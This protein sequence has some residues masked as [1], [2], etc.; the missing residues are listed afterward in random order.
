MRKL[1]GVAV[2]F[3]ILGSVTSLVS[4]S[5]TYPYMNG[6]F[7][8]EPEYHTYPEV[9][10]ELSLIEKDHPNIANVFSLGL[11][12]EKRDIFCIKISDNV[13]TDEKEPE[14]FIC[15]LHH[16]REA[17]AVEVA[18]YI[19]NY[20]TDVYGQP[21]HEQVTALVDNREIYIVP[22]V[23][24]DGKV[25]DD[26]GGSDGE[27]RYWRKNRQPCSN[28]IGTDLNRNYSYQWGGLGSS[29]CCAHSNS[30][31]GYEP[32]DAPETRAVKNFIVNHPDITV[33]LDYHSFGG[34]VL[35][36]WGY[37]SAPLSDLDD[38][39]VHEIIGRQYATITSYKFMKM[40]ELYYTSGNAIDWCYS[41]TKDNE[42]PIFS[43][44]IELEGR[45]FYPSPAELLPLCKKNCE[46]ALYVIS[47][48]DDPYKVLRRWKVS[49]SGLVDGNGYNWFDRGYDDSDW[50]MIYMPDE[51]S[52]NLFY[53]HVFTCYDDT[54]Q[55]LLDVPGGSTVYV[56][57]EYI[58]HQDEPGKDFFDITSSIMVGR[59]LVAV[60]VEPSESV[61]IKIIQRNDMYDDKIW[62]A[63]GESGFTDWYD[64]SYDDSDWEMITLPDT[65]FYGFYRRTFMVPRYTQVF[66]DFG[67]DINVD[68]DIVEIYV[69]GKQLNQKEYKKRT[70]THLHEKINITSYT[71]EGVNLVAVH[72]KN[73]NPF[74]A[75]LIR[76]KVLPDLRITN[77]DISFSDPKPTRGERITIL[78]TVHNDITVPDAVLRFYDGPPEE[79]QLIDECSVALPATSSSFKTMWIYPGSTHEIHVVIDE[80]NTI[81]EPEESNNSAH[82]TVPVPDFYTWPMFG[83]DHNH[84]GVSLLPGDMKTPVEK[85]RFPVYGPV[86]SS[87]VVEDIDND[88]HL[89]VVFGS[90]NT[91]YAVNHDGT[92][93]WSVKTGG[94]IV[95]SPAIADLDNDG[96]ME[97][98]CGSTDDNLYILK[99]ED[100]SL[101]WTF[102]AGDGIYTS[103]VVYDVDNDSK[104]EI[105]FGSSDHMV[106]A[107]NGDT[108]VLW[109]FGTGDTVVSSPAVANLKEVG[110][111][112]VVVGSCDNGVYVLDADSGWMWKWIKACEA[113]FTSSPAV[114]DINGD[115]N[116]EFVIG[117]SD[118]MVYAVDKDGDILWEVAVK[119][120][121]TCPALA[122]VDQNGDVEV[123]VSS[124][125][126][127]CLNG[128]D[129]SLLW[130][131]K[132]FNFSSPAIVDIDG[133]T[134]YEIVV[135]SDDNRVY[136][137]NGRDGTVLWRFLTK[138]S[139][140]PP[141]VADIDGDGYAE[142]IV[143]SRHFVYVLDSGLK[144]GYQPE[145]ILILAG[146]FLGVLMVLLVLLVVRD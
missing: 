87:P 32:F 42:I 146:I 21:G 77:L 82:A 108:S 103:P 62:R 71:F 72:T 101:L 127:Y 7:T 63:T 40:S 65:S 60:Q 96:K 44:V 95:S 122:D 137:I 35:H 9:V 102:T 123:I 97:V 88:D 83:H 51:R 98:V 113:D 25:Y 68:Y 47:C 36:P 129:G 119:G 78:V 46:A 18:L 128:E 41:A 130:M 73:A 67:L 27:G 49:D 24:P 10:S 54:Q 69:N 66:L 85:W 55:V 133:D 126:V 79:G 145:I 22:I 28:G 91:I 8:L 94:R 142:I 90:Y 144:S 138:G 34:M 100:G 120:V 118:S 99:G 64:V 30:F 134:E 92:V 15:A 2:F 121:I 81:A 105:I 136:C 58:K 26:T 38:R 141:A 57:G 11:S 104:R 3:V 143:G 75:T 135:G 107:L 109:E 132:G 56:N 52:Q 16:A 5:N 84:S 80:D 117:S 89:E 23:N 93:L 33:F 114:G 139:T 37:T 115:G 131:V 76:K 70:N 31:R 74:D 20:I 110:R 43:W 116:L 6:L 17:A 124:D 61:D 112:Q 86:A 4:S 140:G 125:Y 1:S 19:I 59:N 45:D 39:Q 106:Y 48:A 53:R 29:N 13:L 12:Y 50:E 14:V 111:L